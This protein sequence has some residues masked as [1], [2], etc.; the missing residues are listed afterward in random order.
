QLAIDH[1]FQ[2]S[3][4]VDPAVAADVQ[5]VEA[6]TPINYLTLVTFGQWDRLLTEPSPP[7]S[8]RFATGMA[9]YARGVA[10]A[11][12]RRW[13][14]AN[15][16]LDSVGR[17]AFAFPNGD[18]R[19]A[20]LIAERALAGEVDLRRGAL[21]GAIRSFQSAVM[22]EDAMPYNEPP[23]WYYPMRHSLGK[24]LIQARRF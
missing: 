1:A 14:E 11:A 7:E 13:A 2:A 24:A 4:S 23:V 8:Q 5:W 10:F 18:N 16:A 12:K 17:T 22:L 6:I 3:A 19:T 20:L 21:S 15:A 9:F